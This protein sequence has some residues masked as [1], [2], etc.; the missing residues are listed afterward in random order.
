MSPQSQSQFQPQSQT[1][2]QPQEKAQ[3]QPQVSRRTLMRGGLIGGGLGIAIAAG[4][5][6][7]VGVAG[8]SSLKPVGKPVVM[9]PMEPAAM[10]GPLVFYVSDPATG[11]I[12]VFGGTGATQVRNPA[13]V[14]QLLNNLK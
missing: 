6:A 5:S 1:Q 2:A 12:D 4:A 13:L 11:L 8:S 10:H 7:A 14:T 3:E 9:A